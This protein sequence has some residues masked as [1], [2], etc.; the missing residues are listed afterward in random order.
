[1]KKEMLLINGQRSS[2]LSE[3][4]KENLSLEVIKILKMIYNIGMHG[5]KLIRKKL[6]ISFALPE[7]HKL[8]TKLRNQQ[9]F[10]GKL[11]LKWKNRVYSLI[12]G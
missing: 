1:M 9:K 8:M 3:L 11:E 10:K 12:S 4:I 7:K 6:T 2:K 5:L